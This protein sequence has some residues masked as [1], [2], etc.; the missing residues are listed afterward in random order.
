MVNFITS[1]GLNF[2]SGK[3]NQH[4]RSI[5]NILAADEKYI[6]AYKK[7]GIVENFFSHYQRCSCLLANYERHLVSYEGL[8]LLYSSSYLCK[9]LN[10]LIILHNDPDLKAEEKIKKQIKKDKQ[11][12]RNLVRK[13]NKKIKQAV[14]EENKILRQQENDASINKLNDLIWNN[15]D[16]K[17][18]NNNYRKS[19]KEYLKNKNNDK[20]GRK[21]DI[22]KEKYSCHIKSKLG[23]YLKD[24]ILTQTMSYHLSGKKLHLMEAPAFAFSEDMIKNTME[25]TD[26]DAVIKNISNN[27]FT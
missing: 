16:K 6:K 27:F 11:I 14:S 4:T 20:R 15:V 8:A 10:K 19:K 9:K 3:N 22:S 13:N 25:K 7:R 1:N 12:E 26:L 24:N 23:N 2:I 21:K 5:A 17:I 18:I